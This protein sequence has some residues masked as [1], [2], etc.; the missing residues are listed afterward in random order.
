MNP[1]RVLAFYE[2][3]P[4]PPTS[5]A[6]RRVWQMLSGLQT[7]GA[8]VRFLSTDAFRF[9]AP[10]HEQLAAMRGVCV[11][12]TD[13]YRTPAA[14][15]FVRRAA[16]RLAQA[17]GRPGLRFDSRWLTF[18]RMR[19][20]FGAHAAAFRPDLIL[21]FYANWHRLLAGLP[22]EQA[23]VPRWLD[24]IDLLTLHDQFFTAVIA[25]L[26]PGPDAPVDPELL[27]GDFFASRRLKPS[28]EEFRVHDRFDRTI[29]ITEAEASVIRAHTCHTVVHCLPM[30]EEPRELG[31]TWAGPA[32][33]T[34]GEAVL[35]RQGGLW[36]IHRVLP[37]L[38]ATAADFALDI[39]GDTGRLLPMAEGVTPRGFVADLD[40]LYRG[41]AFLVCPVLGGTGQLVKVVQAMAAGLPAV[42]LRQNAHRV[43]VT[44]EHDGL[45]VDDAAGFATACAR[46]WRDRALCRRLG[47][48]ARETVRS[49]FS[50]SVLESGLRA[51]SAPSPGNKA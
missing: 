15:N 12:E 1:R 21:F 24:A 16:T 13:C 14:H 26:P 46:L 32:L 4:F 41:A 5:G 11:D 3:I 18:P 40:A 34:T 44:H 38:H 37:E 23:G 50:G 31:N 25:R 35:N 39:T 43:P 29:A 19:R 7:L 48:A 45:L 28:P 2:D 9:R 49:H 8:Q 47:V 27:R 30:T 36:F 17:A 42:V 10:R 22:P 20:W 6:T 51:L 33:F